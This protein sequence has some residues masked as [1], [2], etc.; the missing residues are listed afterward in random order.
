MPVPSPTVSFVVPTYKL[1]HLVGECLESIRAQS[2]EDYEILLMDDC[3]PDDTASVAEAFA[4]PR[5]RYVRNET[6]L[7]HLANYNKGLGLARGRYLWLISADDRLRSTDV[8]SRFVEALEGDPRI[9]FVFCPAMGLRD[10]ADSGI[11]R[12]CWNPPDAAVLEGRDLLKILLERNC[13]AS[14]AVL[15][16]AAA[17]REAGWFPLDLPYAGDW[18]LWC[19]FALGTRVAYLPEPMI[20]YRLHSQSMS[21][22]LSSGRPEQMVRDD[23][24]VRWRI[25][26]DASALGQ[27]AV[28]RMAAE[29]IAG[30][31][32]AR[33]MRREQGLREGMSFDECVSSIRQHA[34]SAGEASE[35]IARMS[36]E[37]AD[38]LRARGRLD[39]ARR[40]YNAAIRR[41]PLAWRALAKRSL[42]TLGRSGVRLTATAAALRDRLFAGHA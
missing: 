38:L 7:G 28:R 12:F 34:A 30:D 21:E 42:L 1:A 25:K 22:A 40:H 16:R 41:T 9:A 4:D 35:A 6:N 11:V 31:Y 26:H 33:I 24:A 37:L 14:P 36:E 23:I 27:T 13:I 3:S 20:H 32:A 29:R 2:F 8:L 5:L 19:R 39:E 17:Y 15:V 10:G 18:Y